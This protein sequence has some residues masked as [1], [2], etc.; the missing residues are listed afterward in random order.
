MDQKIGSWA[1]VTAQ[2]RIELMTVSD[3]GNESNDCRN[4]PQWELFRVLFLIGEVQH[5]T[6]A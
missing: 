2:V 4:L 6:T 3:A 1:G 5:P